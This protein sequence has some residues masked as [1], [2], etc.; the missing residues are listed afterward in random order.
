M[1]AQPTPMTQ[2]WDRVQ[3]R[4]AGPAEIELAGGRGTA[5][6]DERV[7]DFSQPSGEYLLPTYTA[8]YSVLQDEA[9]LGDFVG[10]FAGPHAPSDEEVLSFYTRFG[11]I[12]DTEWQ[13]Q[14]AEEDRQSFPEATRQGLREPVWRA[15]ELASELEV[16]CRLYWGLADRRI[17]VLRGVLGLAPVSGQLVNI[18][19]LGGQVHKVW[20][21]DEELRRRVGSI[22]EWQPSEGDPGRDFT[23][24]EC[25]GYG[26]SLL[27]SAINRHE[28]KAYRQWTA[29]HE[30][31]ALPE[32]RRRS[33]R[34]KPRPENPILG[35]SRGV[36]FPSLIVALYL[37]LSDG[38]A[39]GRLLRPCQGCG[40]YFHPD[41]TDQAYCKVRCSNAY[42]RRQSPHQQDRIDAR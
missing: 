32:T 39:E 33:K 1:S 8:A 6:E 7:V 20:A 24:E 5:Y 23:A 25:F 28:A 4:L 17:D 31:P 11:S 16:S 12:R 38:I 27:A 36:L 3:P 18:L 22:G 34:P 2:V 13:E 41:R 9:V 42:R 14:F 37:K 15:R 19:L 30:L 21:S 10:V 35:G 26:R 40:R 29:R